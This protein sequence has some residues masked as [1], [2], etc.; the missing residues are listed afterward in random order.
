MTICF[1]CGADKEWPPEQHA[2]YCFRFRPP[3]LPKGVYRDGQTLR[4]DSIRDTFEEAP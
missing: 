3:P 2:T 1:W 4:I